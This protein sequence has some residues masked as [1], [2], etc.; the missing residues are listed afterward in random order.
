[1]GRKVSQPVNE[2]M[3]AVERI[4]QH[5]LDFS[6][7]YSAS[8]ELG[9]LCSAVN[10]L[11][12][13]LQDSLE[14]EWRKQEEMR[15]MV[16][17][18]AHDLRT[19]IAIIQGHIEGL[20]RAEAGDKR[21]Q[22][23]ERYL[24]ALEASGRSVAHLLND[25][26]LLSE[27]EQTSFVIQ[28]YRVAL[29]EELARRVDLYTLRAAESGI[30]F[31]YGLQNPS[32]HHPFVMLD[33]HR[34][35]QVLDNLFDTAVRHTPAGGQIS[36]MCTQTPTAVEFILRDSGAG[37]AQEDLPHIWERFYRSTSHP[38]ARSMT[39]TGLGLSICKLL[40]ERQRGTIALRNHP[41]GGCEATIVLPV[42]WQTPEVA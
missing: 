3:S 15:T 40:V 21:N 7:T 30:T 38:N 2:L 35:E 27:L 28:P 23:L 17:A 42:E 10:E 29:D 31:R 8:N 37:I 20:A 18:L 5:D 39:N 13:E 9:D 33:F 6:I 12:Q 36:L 24:P 4:R 22:R 1:M 25:M 19:P 32:A 26:L 14:R 16:A 41:E 11:R 34:L